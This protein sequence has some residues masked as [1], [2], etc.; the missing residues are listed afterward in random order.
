MMM[1]PMMRM[2]PTMMI[3]KRFTLAL[4]AMLAASPAAAQDNIPATRWKTVLTG[5]DGTTVAIDSATIDRA[6]DSIFSVF[7]AV[8][9]AAPVTLSTGETVDREV[10]AE[11]L[12]CG[13]IRVRGAYSE[14][15][16]GDRRVENLELANTWMP[17]AAERRPLFDARCAWLL[18]GFAAQLPR[19]YELDAVEVTPEL[20]N[21]REVSDAISREYP[22]S[23]LEQGVGG[24]TTLRMRVNENGT[25]EQS[26]VNVLT[27]DNPQFGEAA[28][29]VVWGMRFRPARV[30]GR[31]VRVW[32]TL[33]VVFRIGTAP[34]ARQSGSAP[35]PRMVL[36]SDRPCVAR[37]GRSA[38]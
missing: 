9:F 7:T 17:V 36:P 33:P 38:P 14:L 8:R 6:G 21:R 13:G 16:M 26:S 31:A 19:T 37:T 12:D 27:Y 28:R 35:P 20:L 4:L 2:D 34:F 18:G 30:R 25:V 15:W 10:D 11:E 32:V 1:I 5:E 23:M 3:R 22:Q 29:R 24:T